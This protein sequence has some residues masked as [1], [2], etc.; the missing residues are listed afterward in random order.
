MDHYF[1]LLWLISVALWQLG[2]MVILPL[3]EVCLSAEHYEYIFWPWLWLD[4]LTSLVNLI[5][6]SYHFILLQL[7]PIAIWGLG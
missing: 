1:T 6:I 5:Y 7:S 2:Q 4:S 3:L